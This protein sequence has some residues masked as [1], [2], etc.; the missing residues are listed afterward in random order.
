MIHKE[1]FN[2]GHELEDEGECENNNPEIVCTCR[3]HP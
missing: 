2:F 3:Y 1:M